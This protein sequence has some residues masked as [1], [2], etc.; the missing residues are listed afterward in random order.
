MDWLERR[1]ALKSWWWFSGGE[2]L[3]WEC[4]WGGWGW[5]E[6]SQ[7]TGSQIPHG[8]NLGFE[9]VIICCFFGIVLKWNLQTRKT[10]IA[11]LDQFQYHAGSQ[12]LEWRKS[13]MKARTKCFSHCI[14]LIVGAQLMLGGAG[15]TLTLK[16]HCLYSWA[17]HPTPNSFLSWKVPGCSWHALCSPICPFWGPCS[18]APWSDESSFSYSQEGQVS[19]CSQIVGASGEDWEDVK[20]TSSKRCI[21]DLL[22]M[23]LCSWARA[24]WGHPG[25]PAPQGELFWGQ[26]QWSWERGLEWKALLLWR[27]LPLLRGYLRRYSFQMHLHFNRWLSVPETSIGVKGINL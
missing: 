26:A 9:K 11:T 2:S 21:K 17:F 13:P 15:L 22:P 19:T 6:K 25:Q 4:M 7:Q 27:I 8:G 16:A 20:D 18:S 10:T 12:R 3:E 24:P 5:Q 23:L 14:K 1:H